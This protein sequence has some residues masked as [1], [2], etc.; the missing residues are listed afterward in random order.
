MNKII[1]LLICIVCIS[2]CHK[3]KTPDLPKSKG[4]Y[5]INEGNFGFGNA[6]VSFYNPETKTVTN[7]LFK[8]VNGYSLG[9]IA[10]S[11]Y[12]K[13]SL[14]LIV[15]NNSG[16]IEVVTIPSFQKIRTITISGTS[17]R[18]ILPVNDSIAYVTELY[19]NKI[20][21]INYLT[22][23]LKTNIS[24]P[25]FTEHLLRVDEYVFAESKKI[26]S[27]PSSKGAVYRIRIADN[28]FVDKKEFA[29][30]AGGIV[31]DKNKNIWMALDEDSAT[32][33]KASL[34]CLDKNLN[35]VAQ[36]SMNSFGFHPNHLSID[37]NG[38]TLFFV[39]EKSVY[40]ASI[41]NL[42]PT[43]LFSSTV[44]N[45]YSMEV[46]PASGDIYL[47][48]AL[49][50]VQSS[51]IYRHDK[52]GALIHSFTAGVISGNFAFTHE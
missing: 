20:H 23:N 24:V 17:P 40:K 7:D 28:T 13:D 22:G 1:L 37:G 26:Y 21:V 29:G 36:Y 10:Q 38:E 46:D 19:S 34:V 45:V 31:Q 39:A 30:D 42:Q 9:D 32:S 49:D 47:S 25:Q 2:S 16:K 43:I 18:Y 52:M 41:T 3:D 48:D 15:V 14:A 33:T 50:Y 5:I 35:T 44:S 12:I 8:T 27:N 51:H 6:D 11:M 4:V